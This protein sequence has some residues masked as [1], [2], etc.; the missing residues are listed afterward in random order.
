MRS[1][2]ALLA[3]IPAAARADLY[4]HAS[5]GGGFASAHGE[6]IFDNQTSLKGPIGTF[7]LEVGGFVKPRLVVAGDLTLVGSASL[8]GQDETYA[9]GIARRGVALTLY[10]DDHFYG[11]AALGL[12]VGGINGSVGVAGGVGS[13][14]AVG[15]E[16]SVSDDWRLGVEIRGFYESLVGWFIIPISGWQAYGG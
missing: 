16:W 14:L 9:A 12:S 3:L 2:L 1:L 11:A 5:A 8:T 15:Y 6:D 10:F 4:V 13:H 7:D